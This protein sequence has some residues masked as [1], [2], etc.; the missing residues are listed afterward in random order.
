MSLGRQYEWSI[1]EFFRDSK[2]VRNGLALRHTQL[3]RADRFDRFLLV[4]VLAYL[5][6]TGLG[7][8]AMA[9]CRPGEWSSCNKGT[10]CSA[11]MV[12]RAMPG[13]FMLSAAAA[14]AAILAAT[15]TAAQKWG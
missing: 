5:L 7:L 14:I 1:E 15:I 9:Q 2:S 13:R 6:L 3:T 8:R 4:L 11:A 10:P 12:G